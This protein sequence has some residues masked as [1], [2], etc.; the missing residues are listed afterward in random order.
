MIKNN[1]K[2][3]LIKDFKG[4]FSS[5]SKNENYLFVGKSTNWIN[6]PTPDVEYD[7]YQAEIEAWN[8]MLALKKIYP[9][10]VALCVRKIVWTSNTVYDQYDD[11]VDLFSDTLPV[12]FYVIT[13]DKN[14]YKCIS[15]NNGSESL[16]S[17][18]GTGTELVETPDGYIWKYLYS[19]RPELESFITNDYMPVEFL[20]R[21]IYDE[22][23]LRNEQLA[24][25]LDAKFNGSGTI[26][27]IV[28]TQTGAPYLAAIDYDPYPSDVDYPEGLHFVQHYSTRTDSTYPKGISFVGLNKR[29]TEVSSYNGF[30][31]D[32]YVIYITSGPG[33]GEV[34][35][36][37]SYDGT[38]GILAT[39]SKFSVP[40]TSKSAYKILPKV[41]ITGDGSGASAIALLNRE[42]KK[43]EKIKLL[44][45][46]KNYRIASVEVKTTRKEYR[47]KT[48][49]RAIKSQ[50]LGHGGQA[51]MELGCKNLIIK[52]IFD[53]KNNEKLKFFN[54]YRQVG[55]LQNP[56]IINKTKPEQKVVLDVEAFSGSQELNL[57]F[58]STVPVMFTSQ[59]T[60]TIKGVTLI[61]GPPTEEQVVGVIQSYN[62][63]TKVLTVTSIKGRF[64]VNYGSSLATN[65][66]YLKD[67]P[68][69]TNYALSTVKI[70]NNVLKNHYN[71]TTFTTGMRVLTDT[72]YTTAIVDKWIP[73]SDSISGKLTLKS[74][75]G[76]LI[77]S[78]YDITGKFNTGEKFAEILMDTT[79]PKLYLTSGL[80]K[81]GIITSILE[82][83]SDSQDLV[84]RTTA[85]LEVS[86]SANITT[87]F[88]LDTF[89]PDGM[90][91]QI[92]S[93]GNIIAEGVVVDWTVSSGDSTRGRLI[94][95]VTQGAFI[96]ST[97][98]NMYQYVF[99]TYQNVQNTIVC[100]VIAPEAEKYT[101]N[102]IYIDNTP[103]IRHGT[104][105]LEE[106]K[107]VIGF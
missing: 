55:I 46:G 17:P 75:Q 58:T 85:V 24:V 2:N 22:T 95:N 16:Y 43:I 77:P 66:L 13:Q 70:T 1:F 83:I 49:A 47:D 3:S 98:R 48:I 97:D 78:Y 37:I 45:N 56:T 54:E 28:I 102:M 39:D 50:L 86:R 20:D 81:S 76:K 69:Y 29:R 53:P 88:T 35:N 26:S 60:E 8:N 68:E 36:I 30:Y 12:N 101:G 87:P 91:R 42:T 33:A 67:Y 62:P 99:E 84:F 15:N 34:K 5:F 10:E 7:S 63:T 21:L 73:N 40:L 44:K 106:I 65:N 104:D 23:D 92:D 105:S 93:S 59:N 18:V 52:V 25:E 51:A 27:N 61:Q 32:N 71:N 82:T 57:I 107:I 80:S 94:V 11:T 89:T 14:V 19:L 79:N 4:T 90:I 103:P 74:V 9:E 38:S 31:T 41:V 6:E 72:S 96:S 64:R 100:S